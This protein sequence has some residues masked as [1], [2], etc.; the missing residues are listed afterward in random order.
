[1]P[2]QLI[3]IFFYVLIVLCLI[4][5]FAVGSNDETSSA[6][7]GS[8]IIRFK[9]VLV[10]AGI[11]LAVG[12]IFFSQRVGKT[13]GAD[14]LGPGMKYTTFMLFSVL[15]GAIIWLIIGSFREI[16]LSTT[17]CAVG[18]IFGVIIVYSFTVGEVDPST[19]LNFEVLLNIVLGWILAPVFGLIVTIIIYNVITRIFLKRQKGLSQIERSEKIFAIMLIMAVVFSELW[20]GGNNSAVIGMLYGLYCNGSLTYSEFFFLTIVCASFV[21]LGLFFVGKY[22]I[23][24]LASQMTDARPCDGFV[25]LISQGLIMMTATLFALPISH[26]HV[27]VFCIIGLSLA[28]KK[29]IDKKVFFKMTTYWLLTFP[30]SALLAGFIYFGF[31]SFGYL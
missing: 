3:S 5:A 31:I 14:L 26:S 20:V 17:H 22:V 23:R 10:L 19:A 12:M 11:S 2:N 7:V 15:I 30:I 13:V 18:G 27:L 21:F 16:P 1:M 28:Q 9:V 8:G 25:V 24:N 4:T 29:Q 6:L